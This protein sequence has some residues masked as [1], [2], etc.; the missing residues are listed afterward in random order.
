MD[1]L[2]YLQ[3]AFPETRPSLTDASRRHRRV[4]IFRHFPCSLQPDWNRQKL[5]RFSILHFVLRQRIWTACWSILHVVSYRD[6]SHGM[7]EAL[8][9][10]RTPH[11][12]GYGG[13]RPESLPLGA[14]RRGSKLQ[15]Q[16]WSPGELGVS[17][18]HLRRCLKKKLS[19][20]NI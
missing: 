10:T 15:S 18:D 1:H 2:T 20:K 12:M 7:R 6:S 11:K 13:S 3:L 9:S 14:G 17:M 16:P 19:K 4:S 8:S 5:R